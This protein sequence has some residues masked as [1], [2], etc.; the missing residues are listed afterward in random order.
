MEETI[1]LQNEEISFQKDWTQPTNWKLH[2]N[3]PEDWPGLSIVKVETNQT[4]FFS[5]CLGKCMSSHKHVEI[6]FFSQKVASWCCIISRISFGLILVG[7]FWSSCLLYVS[8]CR[9]HRSFFGLGMFHIVF[10][11]E[12]AHSLTVKARVSRWY[13]NTWTQEYIIQ[14]LNAPSLQIW[15][16]T[17]ASGYR[18]LGSCVSFLF[19]F[20][21]LLRWDE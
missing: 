4:N 5:Y 9:K 14:M 7:L 3:V 12:V 13:S 10:L 19:L 8:G 11:K 18:T 1:Q 17:V 21:F 15:P 6:H 2:T 20:Y 16:N